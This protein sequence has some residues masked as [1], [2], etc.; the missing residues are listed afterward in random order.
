MYCATSE[1]F[2]YPKIGYCLPFKEAWEWKKSSG[3]PRW[4]KA[5]SWIRGA[6]GGHQPLTRAEE[7]QGLFPLTDASVSISSQWMHCSP[8]MGYPLEAAFSLPADIHG[9]TSLHFRRG[10]WV[11]KKQKIVLAE[12]W[13][14]LDAPHESTISLLHCNSRAHPGKHWQWLLNY[15][16][17][18]RIVVIGRHQS[19]ITQSSLLA[20]SRF[21]QS[22]LPRTVS[23]QVFSIAKTGDPT[24]SP[25]SL[26]QGFTV[27]TV[28]KKDFLCSWKSPG[29]SCPWGNFAGSCSPW[30]PSRSP[31]PLLLHCSP[32]A[33]TPMFSHKGLVIPPQWQ[34]FA[35][36]LHQV[37]PQPALVNGSTTPWPTNQIFHQFWKIC[38]QTPFWVL[39]IHFK[40]TIRRRN[41][42][43]WT[44]IP[45]RSFRNWERSLGH[46]WM[47]ALMDVLSSRLY[48]FS[49]PKP[50]VKLYRGYY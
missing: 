7:P 39:Q 18:Y 32:D 33:Q 40:K 43:T 10:C 17:H 41:E 48:C 25:V 27:L 4:H 2:Q 35:F 12:L 45:Q 34:D 31:A 8:W 26:F 20:W 9:T 19:G 3:L 38:I 15:S 30:H 50:S 14:C 1:F 36:L 23:H 42:L 6:N 46:W 22:T 24:T 21:T 44:G 11:C 28:K 16:Q 47:R 29:G 37:S 13:Q 5:P 49:R